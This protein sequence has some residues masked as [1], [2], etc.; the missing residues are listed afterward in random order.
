NADEVIANCEEIKKQEKGLVK[1]S[2][3]NGVP[4]SLTQLLR[5][6]EIQKKAGKVGIDW[7]DVQPMIEK[8]VEE[9]QEFQQEVTNMD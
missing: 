6:Y 4:K 7:V 8:A 9:W 1:E 2:V 5:A 3:L